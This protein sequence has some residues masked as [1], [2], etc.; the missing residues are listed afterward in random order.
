MVQGSYIKNPFSSWQ[1]FDS[2]R[3]YGR[4]RLI[5]SVIEITTDRNPRAVNLVG[6]RWIGKTTLLKLLTDREGCFVKPEYEPAIHPDFTSARLLPVYVDMATDPEPEESLRSMAD[7]LLAKV[8]SVENIDLSQIAGEIRLGQKIASLTGPEI[9]ERIRCLARE[10]FRQDMRLII[11]LDHIDQSGLLAGRAGIRQIDRLTEYASVVIATRKMLVDVY[12]ELAGSPLVH[13]L[14]LQR[15]GLLDKDAALALLSPPLDSSVPE[16]HLEDKA[17]LVD[18]IGLHPYLLVRAAR[19]A[20]EYLL[21]SPKGARLT[22]NYVEVELAPALEFIF[23]HLWQESAGQLRAFCRLREREE[24]DLED[25]AQRKVLSDLQHEALI[26]E[27]PN[28]ESA[29]SFFSPLFG[30]F[31][32]RKVRASEGTPEPQKVESRRILE[33]LEL[34]GGTKEGRVLS[35]LVDN[36]GCLVTDETI[37]DRVWGSVQHKHALDTTVARL[38]GKIKQRQDLVPGRI[39]RYR[40]EG[41]SF[42]PRQDR[43][44]VN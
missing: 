24:I 3:V 6:P 40:N 16:F 13:K 42:E 7:D 38:R 18:Y 36:A 2:E 10:V 32:A 15:I 8:S 39:V 22:R 33:T 5:Q 43:G 12:P 4:T 29:Y 19:Q 25:A 1:E 26:C 31:V 34:S 23:E 27:A 11:C 20:Y 9:E 30:A 35:I 28:G 17:L 37:L 14:V 41:F 21:S 44:N